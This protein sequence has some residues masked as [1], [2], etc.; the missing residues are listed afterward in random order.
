VDLRPHGGKAGFGRDWCRSPRFQL[1]GAVSSLADSPD[2]GYRLARA[3][4][5]RLVGRSLISLGVV[6]V[7]VTLFGLLFDAGWVIAGAATAIGL[8]VIAVW[9]WWLRERAVAVRLTDLGYDVRMLG[10]VGTTTASWSEVAEVVA[11]SPG[12]TPCLVIR[13]SDGRGTR[14]PMSALAVDPDAFAHDVRRRVRNA[15]SPAPAPPDDPAD[16]APDT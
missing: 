13:L 11:A 14:L 10:G 9:A 7:A 5:L 2:T 1:N 12:G 6:V 4:G 3:L 8:V 16:D 15:H